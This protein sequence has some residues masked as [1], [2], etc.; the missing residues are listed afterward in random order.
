[1]RSYGLTPASDNG[2]SQLTQW[3]AVVH[4]INRSDAE[5]ARKQA[6]ALGIFN[7]R[8]TD[9]CRI[10]KWRFVVRAWKEMLDK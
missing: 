9:I 6:Q 5:K 4:F 8:K 1:M 3:G 10:S 2:F 7:G